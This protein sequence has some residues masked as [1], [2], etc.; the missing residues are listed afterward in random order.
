MLPLAMLAVPAWSSVIVTV[1]AR[2]RGQQRHVNIAAGRVTIGIND[3][4]WHIEVYR[5]GRR[6]RSAKVSDFEWVSRNVGVFE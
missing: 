4:D 6:H 2:C 1:G 3:L 5:I